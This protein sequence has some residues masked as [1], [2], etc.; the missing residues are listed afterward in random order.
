MSTTLAP[1]P[2]AAP[3]TPLERDRPSVTDQTAAGRKI[4]LWRLLH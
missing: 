3:H 2:E 1:A 4:H